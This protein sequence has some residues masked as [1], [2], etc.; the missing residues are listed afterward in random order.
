[1]D[2]FLQAILQGK[3]FEPS[4]AEGLRDLQVIETICRSIASGKKESV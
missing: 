4:G 1:M 2:S 3:P